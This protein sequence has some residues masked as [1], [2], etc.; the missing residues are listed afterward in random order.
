MGIARLSKVTIIT[1][2]SEYR[3]VADALAR[4]EEFHPISDGIP[5][6]DEAVQE[7][8]VKAVRLFAQADQAVKDL[9]LKVMP[10]SIDIVF[11]GVKIPR[12]EFE[13]GTWSELLDADEAELNPIVGEVRVQKT[14]LQKATKEDAEAQVLLGAL[15]VV[16]GFSANLSGIPELRRFK[17]VLT[18][19][20]NQAVPEFRNSLPEAIFLTQQLSQTLSIVLVAS[21]SSEED[22]VEKTMKGLELK[23]LQIPPGLPQNPAEAYQKLAED[24]KAAEA[25]IEAIETKM[26]EIRERVGTRLLAARELAEV[27]RSVLDEARASGGMSRMAMISGYVPT[28][29]EEEL[30]EMFGKWMVYA[31]PVNFETEGKNLPTLTENRKGIAL[32]QPVV[33]E[34]GTP[35]GHE[36]DPT[37]IVSFVFPIF[38]G[39]MF[40][41]VGHGLILTLFF[42]LVRQRGT[43]TMRQWANIFI[44]AGLSAI[45]FGVVF[46]EFFELPFSEF[47]PIPPLI[48]I[49]HRAAGSVDSFNFLPTPFA[50]VNLIMI[51]SILIGVA[52][53]TTGLS[54]DVYQGFKDHDRMEVA[55]EKIPVLTMYLSGVGYGLAFIGAGFKFNVLTS[56]STNPLLGIPNN[57]LGGVSLAVL[58]PSML[59]LLAG[60]SVA[61]ATGRLKGE[62]TLGALS[63]GGLEVFERISQFLSNTISYVRLAVML[64]VH[65]ALLLIINLMQPWANPVYIAPWVVLNLL[66][67]TF[68]A[69]IV[70]VQDLRLH[71]YEFFTKFFQGT[72]TPFRKILPD[73]VRIDIKWKA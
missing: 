70:Y 34:Q 71:L 18:V 35:G 56:T 1:P 49:I 73:R 40:G 16:S 68:E 46:G 51:V 12:T 36:V 66:I 54:L 32:F 43:G 13:A 63:N 58:V 6:F 55:L 69:F 27:A 57:L 26:A 19:V 52:H 37:P 61:I 67:L 22:K 29:K 72:G 33:S 5:R 7:L 2:R 8:T 59:V 28:K 62:S 25:Q 39:M 11:K 30:R 42:L 53:L 24:H 15:E 47:V 45:F 65:A 38:F 41:D 4:F 17:A 21:R 23:P 48:E 10:G 9:N 20:N 14:A 60:K 31:E 44:V 3:H 64:L 50:G